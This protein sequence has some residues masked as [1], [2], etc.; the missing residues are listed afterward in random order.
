M[1]KKLC[2]LGWLTA[3]A[4]WRC[5]LLR[6][7]DGGCWQAQARILN[8][9]THPSQPPDPPPGIAL[10]LSWKFHV[11]YSVGLVC[12]PRLSISLS[13][14][15]A[16]ARSWDEAPGDGHVE[17]PP[18]HH[19]DEQH[20]E[21]RLRV[22]EVHALAH[23]QRLS[24]GRGLGGIIRRNESASQ[25]SLRLLALAWEGKLINPPIKQTTDLR[26]G[27]A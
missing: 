6:G 4:A 25:L 27:G 26:A 19:G 15:P 11:L 8:T 5:W 7:L 10:F 24:E 2:A 16:R 22:R 18:D 3:T 1:L 12:P 23:G 13:F 20:R 21:L 17:P 9:R 14:A